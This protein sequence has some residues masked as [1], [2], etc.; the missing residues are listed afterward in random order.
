RSYVADGVTAELPSGDIGERMLAYPDSELTGRVE[1]VAAMT[2]AKGVEDTTFYRYNR[3]VA[4]NEVGSDPG[5]FGVSVD[6]FHTRMATFSDTSMTTLS[7]HDTKRSEDVRARLAV[8]AGLGAASLLH[9]GKT[10]AVLA[11]TT[12]VMALL[13]VFVCRDLVTIC[14]VIAVG[15]LA[16]VTLRWAPALLQNCFAY[17]E[18]WLL[19]TSEIAGVAVIVLNHAHGQRGTDDADILAKLTLIPAVVWVAG[20]F[21]L[22]GWGL[23][24]AIPLLWP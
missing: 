1:Q 23:W 7:T 9:H 16:F 11:L 21:V 15:G 2:M 5:R 22:I 8:L 18:T 6:E 10:A 4:L 17:A 19:L 20:W 12:V 24:T 13:L 14:D 3:F